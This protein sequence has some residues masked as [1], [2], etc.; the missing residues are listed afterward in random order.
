MRAI[1]VRRILFA[2][3][4]VSL[5]V[6]HLPL[7]AQEEIPT[8]P[9]FLPSRLIVGATGR[10]TPGS[11]NNVRSTPATDGEKL[12]QIPGEGVFTVLEGPNCNSDTAWWK[13]DYNGLVGWTVEGLDGE[14]WLEPNL[15]CVSQFNIGD[16]A[17]RVHL[18]L[19]YA[20]P[21][22][23][24]SSFRSPEEGERFTVIG[25]PVCDGEKVW[26][27]VQY[28][29]ITGWLNE[30]GYVL[31]D[32][33]CPEEPVALIQHPFLPLPTVLP[34]NTINLPD[35]TPLS[36]LPANTITSA[37][38]TEVELTNI[39]GT[40]SINH[41]NWLPNGKH[42]I[43][44]TSLA[45]Q[46]YDV[47]AMQQPLYGL[48]DTGGIVRAIS[49]TEDKFLVASASSDGKLNIRDV[50]TSTLLTTSEYDSPIQGLAFT[51]DG[52]AL[53]VMQTT[54]GISLLD[55][56]QPA[57]PSQ[58]HH[59]DTKLPLYKT[60]SFTS[61]SQI[62]ITVD[63]G[64][65]TI[66]DLVSGDSRIVD[67]FD[68]PGDQILRWVIS[69]DDTQIIALVIRHEGDVMYNHD[70]YVTS[71]MIDTGMPGA[72][73]LSANEFA[74]SAEDRY[75]T[76]AFKPGTDDLLVMVLNEQMLLSDESIIHK[77]NVGSAISAAYSPDGQIVAFGYSDGSIQLYTESGL[78]DVLYGIQNVVL[79][80]SFSPDG[81]HLAAS[82]AD[83]TLRV[84]EVESRRRLGTIETLYAGWNF[85][86]SSDEQQI[87]FVHE[88]E[89]RDINSGILVQKLDLST[90]SP[91]VFGSDQ[92]IITTQ[93]INQKWQY[94]VVD[95][96]QNQLIK[97]VPNEFCNYDRPAISADG[98]FFACQLIRSAESALDIIDVETGRVVQSLKRYLQSPRDLIFSPD[99]RFLLVIDYKDRSDSSDRKK[100]LT[101]WEISSGQLVFNQTLDDRY[102]IPVFSSNAT[103]LALVVMQPGEGAIALEPTEIHVVDFSTLEQNMI[104]L[105]TNAAKP[106]LRTAFAFS[107]DDSILAMGRTNGKIDLLNIASGEILYTLEGHLARIT[108][109]AFTPDG[110]RL[111]SAAEDGTLRVWGIP[112]D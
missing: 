41:F 57:S 12:G 96:A 26:I 23:G 43:I 111:Y 20:E 63:S 16:E 58:L 60:L 68:S 14:Y 66:Y 64:Q 17:E 59:W 52:K 36:E 107:A 1:P 13:V 4:L 46:V 78:V 48:T 24:T 8:C 25:G 79:G 28:G 95:L 10:V 112:A 83:G 81:K 44:G 42:L 47:G 32:N 62:M 77:Y 106:E 71:W 11:S 49:N 3:L 6:V 90:G 5:F 102:V 31:C 97:T 109:L 93:F 9:G 110:T 98:K 30:V 50:E 88:S 53:V 75:A 92:Q 108:Q 70:F 82:G 34:A 19:V 33:Y 51:P 80:I 69:P 54:G 85:R 87:L 73:A 55:V 104:M 2:M 91:V 18:V 94:N 100:E 29:K 65:L 86:L 40:G 22:F 101:V 35:S 84:W 45:M 103:K 61:D 76:L 39:I 7:T 74:E 27:Q 15:P 89:I 21:G 99:N 67:A 37:R 105:D 56:S 72:Y 38:A